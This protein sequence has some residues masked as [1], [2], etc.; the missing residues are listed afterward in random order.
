MDVKHNSLSTV[1]PVVEPQSVSA[2]SDPMR[3]AS[4]VVRAELPE[5]S[6]DSVSEHRSDRVTVSTAQKGKALPLLSLEASTLEPDTL[7]PDTVELG[8]P[9]GKATH[10]PQEALRLAR[11]IPYLWDNQDMAIVQQPDGQ[12]QVFE[13]E[14]PLWIF[15]DDLNNYQQLRA[16][17]PAQITG[18]PRLYAIMGDDKNLRFLQPEQ[19]P[20]YQRPGDAPPLLPAS[21]GTAQRQQ[22]VASLQEEFAAVAERL[23][24]MAEDLGASGD[25]RGIFTN[26]YNV[27]T[28][29]GIQEVQRLVDAGKWREAEF[30]GSLCIDFANR[31]FDAYDAYTQGPI[32][33]VPEAWRNAFD[34]GRQAQDTG[35]LKGSVSKV[36]GLSIVAHIINDLPQTLQSI[37]YPDAEDRD[38][39]LRETYD[40]FDAALMDQKEH[41]MGAL[42]THYG[43]SDTLILDT[44]AEQL[45]FDV[46]STGQKEL[47]SLMRDT[48]RVRAETLSQEHIKEKAVATGDWVRHLVPGLS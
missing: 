25:H 2:S 22:R 38:S 30:L 7:E 3:A 32:E 6:S 12:Y 17:N 41:I 15:D 11:R 27:T 23:T 39:T 28:Q 1:H 37:G 34:L 35:V 16:L 46:N 24:A 21:A 48:A 44:I 18:E 45:P 4:E 20:A 40:F 33:D 31:Y 14:R 43:V 5:P 42:A 19:G 36:L 13:L 47:F 29:S 9:L 26:L 8:R 10:S